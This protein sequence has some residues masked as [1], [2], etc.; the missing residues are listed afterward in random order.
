MTNFA[1]DARWARID[2]NFRAGRLSSAIVYL[3]AAIGALDDID[4]VACP[5]YKR[6]AAERRA[7]ITDFR[8]TAAHAGWDA[9]D[10][11]EVCS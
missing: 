7:L 2:A 11:E 6:V 4:T 5:A 9:T 8:T 1:A 10:I 3:N